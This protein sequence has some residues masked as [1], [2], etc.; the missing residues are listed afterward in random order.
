MHERL[1]S[2]VK[3]PSQLQQWSPL[4][5]EVSECGGH[6]VSFTCVRIIVFL[7]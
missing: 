6:E 5:E 2:L 1:R 3:D 4:G 7:V